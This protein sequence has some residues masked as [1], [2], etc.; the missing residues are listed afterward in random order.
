MEYIAAF[1]VTILCGSLGFCGLHLVQDLHERALLLRLFFVAFILRITFTVLCYETGIIN[2]LG[3]MD[4]T[5]WMSCW[6]RSQQ[7]QVSGPESLWTILGAKVIRSN[8]GFGYFATYFYYLLDMRSQMALACLNCFLNAL[9][10]VL[11]YKTAREFFSEKACTFVAWAAAFMPA[12]LIWSAL[13]IKETWLILIEITT[14]F[15]VLRFSRQRTIT[16]LLYIPLTIALILLALSLRFYV[17]SFLVAGILVSSISYRSQKP[18]RAAGFGLA[19]IILLGILFNGLGVVRFDP[20]S[21]AQSQIQ[22]LTQFRDNLA[23]P[24][25]GG[26]SSVRLGYDTTTLSGAA[27]MLLV[28]SFYLLLSP[29]P[30][31]I[32]S[33]RQ[34]FALPDVLLWWVLVFAFVLPGIR[35]A[36]QRQPALLISLAAFVL[37]LL[38]FYAMMFGNVGLAYRQRAQLMPFLLILAAAG[39]ESRQRLTG[40]R[41]VHQSARKLLRLIALQHSSESPAYHPPARG[42]RFNR[43]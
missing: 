9:T 29:F 28:G 26:A 3:N 1:L 12:F 15:I 10:V 36:W 5:I 20:A 27:M 32:V 34:I 16:R 31:E 7:W 8:P 24:R 43:Y 25:F 13:T 11:I 35:Y 19:D 17:A 39:Y 22:E 40:R 14:L 4:D 42:P 23:D 33:G 37:P 38:L 30:W 21:M 2:V 18:W 6:A 41:E